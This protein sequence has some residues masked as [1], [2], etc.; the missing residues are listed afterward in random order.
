[1]KTYILIGC[2]LL[3]GGCASTPTIEERVAAG[4]D[5]SDAEMRLEIIKRQAE[6]EK[7]HQAADGFARM[8][9]KMHQE[10]ARRDTLRQQGN[11]QGLQNM[12][13][14]HNRQWSQ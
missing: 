14:Y 12:R 1:M 6:A 13:D 11:M 3:V 2:L 9:D 7:Y 10:N 5:V 4:E 8:A